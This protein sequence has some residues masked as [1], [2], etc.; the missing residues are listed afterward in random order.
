MLSKNLNELRDFTQQRNYKMYRKT[1]VNSILKLCKK[2]NWNIDRNVSILLKTMCELEDPIVFPNDKIA[3]IRTNINVPEYYNKKVLKKAY[4]VNKDTCF[5]P[6]N[7]VCLDWSILLQKGLLGQINEVYDLY[8]NATKKE[9]KYLDSVLIAL[10]SVVDLVNRYKICAQAVGNNFVAENLSVV[11][12][13]GAKTF[14]Q[15]LQSIRFVHSMLYLCGHAHMGL[16]R[17]DQYLYP[18]YLH[19]IENHIITKE[20]AKDLIAEFFI[21]LNKDTDLYFGVQQGD[22]GQSLMLGGC[23]PEDG[24]SAINELTYLV[25]NVSKEVKL[26][27]PKINLRVDANTPDNLLELGSEL[28][29]CGLGFP[30]YSND[31]VVIPALVKAGYELEDARNYVVA[32]CWEFIIPG[33]ACEK[34]NLGALNFSYAVDY[35]FEKTMKSFGDFNVENFYKLIKKNIKEQIKTLIKRKKVILLPSPLATPFFPDSLRQKKDI[36][37]SSKY[38]N[39]GIHGAGSSNAADSIIVIKNI[40]KESGKKGL[41][42]LL[43]AKN[44]NFEGYKE[45][46]DKV[47][48]KMPKVGNANKDVDNE[49][50]LLFDY[51]ADVA[52]ELSNDKRKIRPG[53]G[54]AMYYLLLTEDNNKDVEP[55]VRAGV[56]GRKR[57]EPFSSSLSPSHGIMVD[58]VLSVLKSFSVIDYSRINNGGPITIEFSKSV[59]NSDEGIKKMAQLLKYFIKLGN[60]QLQLNVLD[61]N[62]LEDAILHPENHKNLIVRVWG[63]SGYFT[64]LEKKYQQ[65]ILSRHQYY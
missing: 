20:E 35:A 19:D 14:A 16:G 26:I 47:R 44:A 34:V 21:S 57:G 4:K 31:D 63:W 39:I 18:Y 32:A 27:D 42:E 9:R 43:T 23:K 45:L 29:K 52:E 28:T 38:N 10:N 25:L 12:L 49:L 2:F 55:K 64:E 62:T 48:E 50:K 65:Q 13:N 30:Q 24:S 51:F 54:S 46:F 59:F 61:K 37:M 40:Y 36:T 15:A 1:V 5:E 33:K 60:Q 6:F 56:D 8:K 3:F 22:N 7:N 58:G 41:K 17:F 11:P 53:S